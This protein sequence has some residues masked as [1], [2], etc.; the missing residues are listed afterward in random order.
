[1]TL[2]TSFEE[3]YFCPFDLLS[4]IIEKEK[5]AYKQLFKLERE[6][7]LFEI[8]IYSNRLTYRS[9]VIEPLLIQLNETRLRMPSLDLQ[10]F[11]NVRSDYVRI[12]T[13][14]ENTL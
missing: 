6:V 9:K 3:L 12:K 2:T 11:E 13:S 5:V 10:V 14:W 4:I 1:M 7:V 8:G